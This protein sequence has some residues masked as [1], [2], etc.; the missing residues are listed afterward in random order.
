M[1]RDAHYYALLAFCR[2]SGFHKKNAYQI[3]Y[4]SQFVDDA[5]INLI[6][7]QDEDWIDG[8][9]FVEDRPAF[10]NMATCHSYFRIDTFNF[11][12]M[13]NNTVA[14]HFVPGCQGESFTKK[15]RCKE[16]SPIIKDLLNEAA[17]G[18]DL[19]K[20]G[21][22]LHAYAD[23]FSH[24]GF[25]GL[26]SK[27]NDIKNCEAETYD[28]LGLLEESLNIVKL[29]TQG[30]FDKYL[31]RLMPAYGHCQATEFP[32]IPG[33]Q[34]SYA[35]DC[36]NDFKG[37]YRKVEIDN[38]ERYTRAFL[39]I[40]KQLAEYL[41]KHEQYVDR[42]L[43]YENMDLLM[44]MLIREGTDSHREERWRKFLVEQGLFDANDQD[45][46]VYEDKR[47]L[48]EAF[49]NFDPVTFEQRVVFG[50]KLADNF[51][52]SNWYRFFQAVQ[53]YKGKFPGYCTKY[54]LIIP[55]YR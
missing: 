6:F 11:E 46:L 29:M 17:N 47:W 22:A 5:K 32:D 55:G 15:L 20:L 40:R 26:L 50:A 41:N 37:S 43:R 7:C 44:D 38:K 3:A 54:G 34:W 48:K 49:R 9:I 12:E 18:D 23:S 53:W 51:L 8:Q 13:L 45:L 1:K 35:Y 31:D 24:Q 28:S 25:S 4:A 2:A 52:N 14:F 27:V 42:S 30:K 36:S 10:F 16:E 33:L 19:M 39:C 21:I